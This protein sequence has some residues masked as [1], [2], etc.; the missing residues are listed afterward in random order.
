MSILRVPR[1]AALSLP[2]LSLLAAVGLSAEGQRPSAGAPSHLTV[3][4]IAVAVDLDVTPRFGWHVEGIEQTA[5]E[6]RVAS[7]R[8][9]AEA[10]DADV[11]S[12]GKV[13]SAQQNDIRYAGPAL[14]PAERYFWTARTWGARGASAWSA[15][16]S[17]G[18]GPGASWSG[19]TPIWAQPT[20][21]DWG[22]YTLTTHLTIDEVALGIRFRSPDNDNGYMW[23]LRGA[24]NRLVPHRLVNGSFT[25]I[26]S[27]SLPAGTLAVG[28]AVELRIEAVGATIRTFIDGVLVH[29]LTDAT[30]PR[31]GVGVR[32]GNGESG[33]LADVALV[34]AGGATLL[35]TDFVAGDRSFACGSVQ[36]GALRVPRAT[37]CLNSGARVDWAFM[38]K[39]FTL[40]DKPLAW[41]TLYATATSPLPARQ[42][43]YQLALDGEP[44]GLGPTQSIGSELRYDG[45]DVTDRLL[46]GDN[47]LGVLAY[48]TSGRAFRAELVVRYAD[49]TSQRVGSDGSWRAI[50]GDFAFP[51]AGSIGTSYYAAPRENLDARHYPYGFDRPGFDDDAWAPAAE[52][53]MSGEL[54]AA[55]MAKVA[56]QL[57]APLSIVEKGAG[58]YF[59][60]FGRTWV[61][62]VQYDVDNGSAGASV[63]VRYGEV[64]SAP[65]TVRHQLNT[66]NTYQDIYT[67][68]DGTQTFS[69]WGLRVFRYVEIIGAPEPVSTDNLSALALVYPFDADGAQFGASDAALEDVWQLSKDTIEAVN[70]NFYTD[71]WTRERTNYEADAYLQLLSSLYLMDDLS[72][73]R[74]ST[75][76]F[77]GSAGSRRTWPTEWPLY[78]IRAVHDAWQ[79]TG[80]AQPLQAS[81]ASL[82]AKLPEA[83]FEP[84]TQLI[85]KDA[86]SNGC[87]SVTDCDIVDWPQS[88]RD[89]FA[90]RPYNTVVNALAYRAY[91]DMAAIATAIGEAA[92][93]L[94]FATRADSLRAAINTRLY[95]ASSGRYDDGMDASGNLTGHYSLHASAFALAFGVPDEAEAPR[96]ADAVA[97]RGMACSVYGAAFLTSGLYRAGRAEAALG[98]L[99][100]TGTASWLNMIRLGAGATAEA[101]DPAFKSNLSY[102][103]PW[104]ASPAFAVPAGLFGIEP[105]EPGY[106][107]FRVRPQPG[108]LE[109]AHV[110][111]PSV[112]GR[113]GVAFDHAASGALQL[114]LQVPGNTRAELSV[115]VAEGTALLYVDQV[116]HAVTVDAG[117][118]DLPALAAGCHVIS[119]EPDSDAHLDPGLIGVCTMPPAIAPEHGQPGCVVEWLEREP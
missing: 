10:A 43:V 52:R 93:A 62:G 64:T 78:V 7:T 4:G 1:R 118:A 69:T 32:T 54:A 98:L 63:E 61:G 27:V 112:R 76:Y 24:D 79:Q 39:E 56:R 68:K 110:S 49:G 34:D 60:D 16:S 102:S 31:G 119:P 19:S 21:Q 109:H 50:S 70:V 23:Q 14:A 35:A 66:G 26:E 80:D 100:A 83:W 85:R 103:H 29:Q 2:A 96:V 81:Y 104:A 77:T 91:R 20:S 42:Y 97:A 105:L 12:S 106:A 9:R 3:N 36:A 67:L 75:S 40:E 30:F 72:L 74:Y 13:A 59:I 111:V 101:W 82:K 37:N 45:F 71:S 89:G 87:D 11:W 41:A 28:R 48:T 33:T 107:R 8:A 38:R 90:F 15:V 88:Q 65:E 94:T 73:G 113:I 6:I 116:P 57:E 18:T 117:Y 86:G 108:G 22:D 55:P 47:A 46:P 95:D 5:Y 99:T 84:A 25:V 114:A 17:F 51:A 92:D 53:A 115:P 58:H 44:V